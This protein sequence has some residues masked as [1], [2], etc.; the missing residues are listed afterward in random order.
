[1]T[2]GVDKTAKVFN[3]VEGK[4]VASLSGHTKRVSDVSFVAGSDNVVTCS[5]DSSVRVWAKSG[6]SYAKKASVIIKAHDAEVTGVA[7]HPTAAYV[8]SSSLD[9]TWAFSDL[10]TGR[11]YTT[12]K[13]ED[14]GAGLEC[15]AFHPD[16]IIFGTGTGANL[17][18]MWDVNTCTN[19][20]TFEGH[21]GVVNSV[22]FSENGYHMASASD[23]STVR[24]YDLRKLK[25]LHEF[26]LGAAAQSVSFDASGKFLAVGAAGVAYVA[27]CVPFW[28]FFAR[29]PH[30]I[31]TAVGCPQCVQC[32]GWPRAGVLRQSLEASAGCFL[33]SCSQI[34]CVSIFGPRAHVLR[35]S[36]HRCVRSYCITSVQFK[37]ARKPQHFEED[38]FQN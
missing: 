8:V 32:Q 12:S 6:D 27:C 26:K 19:V 9:K 13:A 20:A 36:T 14:V 23:D 2:G 25:T 35:L 33:R 21:T 30:L 15:V 10:E 17:V 5:H 7:V 1:V 11:V 4:V 31:V 29:L 34:R 38:E 3:R 18:R 22:A 28:P 24:V 16:G 37:V